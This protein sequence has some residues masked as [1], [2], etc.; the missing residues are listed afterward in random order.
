[1][2]TSDIVQEVIIIN[3]LSKR[4]AEKGFKQVIQIV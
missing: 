1:M 4:R 3:A 2:I